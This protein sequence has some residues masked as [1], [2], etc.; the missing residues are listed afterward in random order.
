MCCGVGGCTCMC[1]WRCVIRFMAM[2][3][4]QRPGRAHS[5]VA[6]PACH[7]DFELHWHGQ[8]AGSCSLRATARYIAVGGARS[9]SSAPTQNT[10]VCGPGGADSP[11]GESP[12]PHLM[13]ARPRPAHARDIN[14]GARARAAPRA[15][16]I[17]PRAPVVRCYVTRPHS[18]AQCCCE[19]KEVASRRRFFSL[20]A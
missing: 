15:S 10:A 8:P 7:A 13:A 11:T 1:I 17:P 5:T 3:M 18:A 12:R 14:A 4:A 2:R 9:V 16:P 20:Y 6:C 19:Q